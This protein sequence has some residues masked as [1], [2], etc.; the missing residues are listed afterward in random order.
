LCGRAVA[1]I[2]GAEDQETAMPPALQRRSLLCYLAAAAAASGA[3]LRRSVAAESWPTRSVRI[4]VPFAPGGGADSSARVLAEAMAP[5]L[6]APMIVENKPGAGSAIGVAYAAQSRDGHTLLMGSNSMVI[7]PSLNPAV[8]YDVERDF[9]VVGMVSAQPLVL[10]VPLSSPIHSVADLLAQ[11]KARPGQLTAG[12]SGTGTLAHL[13]SEIFGSQTGTTLTPV[14][15]KGESALMPDL[16]SGVIA[17]GFLNLPSVLPQ[18]KSGRLR[19]IAV[20]SPLPLPELPG[21]PTFDSLGYPSLQVQGWAALFAARGSIPDAGL[22]RLGPLLTQALQSP[23]VRQRFTNLGVTP[24]VMDRKASAEFIE[25][26][27]E[28]YA[29]VIKSR[30]IR[31]Q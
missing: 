23:G 2:I 7:N 19:A 14:P 13:A 9:D 8:G 10:V 16:I 31:L 3:A 27:T 15:Y 6:G 4:I 29:A 5:K 17:L 24:L 30:N 20:S 1:S 26:E 28:R 11:A 25:A 18:I 22:A 12:N 21:V